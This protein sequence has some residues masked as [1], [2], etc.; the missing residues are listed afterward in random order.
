MASNYVRVPS[1]L[2]LTTKGDLASYSTAV[3]RLPVGTDAQVLVADSAQALG[4]KWATPSA[5]GGVIVGAAITSGTASRVLYETAGN[6]V[7]ESSNLTFN[8][9]YL[10]A[11]SLS[12]G[13][14]STAPSYEVQVFGGAGNSTIQLTNT[15]SGNAS[16]DGCLLDYD[17][18]TL[19]LRNRESGSVQFEFY[20]NSSLLMT[21]GTPGQYGAGYGDLQFG[22]GTKSGFQFS[23][24]GGGYNTPCVFIRGDCA[25]NSGG[26]LLGGYRS[27]ASITCN[28]FD[29][30]YITS[31]MLGCVDTTLTPAGSSPNYALDIRATAAATAVYSQYTIPTTTGLA[32]TDGTKVGLTSDG[33]F[34]INNQETSGLITLTSARVVITNSVTPASAAAAGVAGTVAW[35]SDYVYVCTAANTWK[36]SAIATW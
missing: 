8:G 4:I 33:N 6:L 1:A 16:T 11:T 30:G 35:D 32:T 22:T 34:V 9:T 7:G 24:T 27:S 25:P 21:L 2:P 18:G 26:S 28:A 19:A 23:S 36:R 13:A 31:L 10:G 20:T 12:V 17:G 14:A 3:A 5:G 15:A 29:K